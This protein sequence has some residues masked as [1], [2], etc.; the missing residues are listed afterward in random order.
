MTHMKIETK[1]SQNRK[2]K[3]QEMYFENLSLNCDRFWFV[4]G[5]LY[6][7]VIATVAILVLTI[8]D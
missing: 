3:K 2:L 8:S 4:K 7:H 1:F 5:L 6:M